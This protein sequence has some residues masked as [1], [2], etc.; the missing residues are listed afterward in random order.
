MQ[1]LV[2]LAYP[3][4]VYKQSHVD[5]LAEVICYVNRLRGDIRGLRMV[6]APSVLRHYSARI[7]P[8]Q[9]TFDSCGR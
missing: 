8:T 3:R 2:R 6:E 4:R 5:Y 1:A 9:V 7:T